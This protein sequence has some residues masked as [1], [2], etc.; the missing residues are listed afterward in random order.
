MYLEWRVKDI[1]EINQEMGR[2]K[3][4]ADRWKE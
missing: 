2:T 4:V 1:Q 3:G